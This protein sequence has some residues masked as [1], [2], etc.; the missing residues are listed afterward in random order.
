MGS[1]RKNV[2]VF[3]LSLLFSLPFASANEIVT[4]ELDWP[5][6]MIADPTN[7]NVDGLGKDII[8]ECLASRNYRVNYIPLPIK[9]ISL[10]MQNGNLDFSIYSYK[11]E[12]EAFLV[13]SKVPIF[14]VEV[15]FMVRADS[16]IKI[17]SLED[18]ALLRIGHLAG[19]THTPEIL[20]IINQK[21]VVG[22]LSEGHNIDAMFAQLLSPTPRFD[23]MPDS[24]QTFYWR[25]KQ[26]GILDK[27][28]VLP[29][30]AQQKDYFISVS[31]KSK[32]ITNVEG[33]LTTIDNCILEMHENGRYNKL[34]KKYGL[35]GL[36]H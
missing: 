17:D 34:L 36:V 4:F 11:K 18:L 35:D 21:R 19:L 27:I 24:K 30:V 31:Q 16:D 6:Y 26:L 12:R 29:F 20:D 15:G 10:F 13:Y 5:P 9:R 33:F 7:K 23:I 25:A 28:K 8:N 1:L 22:D 3:I 2:C 32:N 14:T